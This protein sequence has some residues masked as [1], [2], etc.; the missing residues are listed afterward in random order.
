MLQVMIQKK[1][2]KK[3]KEGLPKCQLV[4]Q[5]LAQ[6]ITCTKFGVGRVPGFGLAQLFLS[7]SDHG[8]SSWHAVLLSAAPFIPFPAVLSAGYSYL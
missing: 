2:K 3:K 8:L 6:A 5:R 4:F 1:K 7:F